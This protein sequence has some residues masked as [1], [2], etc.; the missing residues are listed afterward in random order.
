MN[1]PYSGHD[2]ALAAAARAGDPAALNELFGRQLPM[3]YNLVRR[4][5]HDDPAVDDVVQDVLVRAL[6]QIGRLRS[7]GSFRPWLAA[8]AVRQIS[9]H[10]ARTEV[11]A[12]REAPLEAAYRRP[13]AGAEVEGPALLRAELSGQRR[14]VGHAL[15]WMGADE[16]ATYSLWW[17]EMLG[18]LSRPEV[19][20]ALGTSVAHAGVRMQ[21]MREQLEASRQIVAAL[22]AMPGC[23]TLGQVAAEWDGTPSSFWRKRLGRHVQS[24]PVCARATARLLPAD[25]LLVGLM[26]FPVPAALGAAAVAKALGGGAAAASGVKVAS[27]VASWLGRTVQAAVTHPV[28]ATVTAGVLAVGVTVPT[29]G[30]TTSEAPS[31]GLIGTTAPPPS[32]SAARLAIGRVSLESAGAPGR[33]VAVAADYGVLTAVGPASDAAARERAGLSAVA[34]LA[35]PAC[36]SFRRPDGRY[37]RHSSFRLRLSTAD[38]TVLFR[39]DATFCARTG[40]LGGSV[41]LESFN[42]RGFFLRHVG[43]QMWIDQYDGSTEFRADG[44]FFVRPPLG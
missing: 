15:R 37:L 7:V 42:Y 4:A 3:V 21:R 11:A 40:F 44:S 26:L 29:T 18:E 32:A 22:E 38:G 2:E 19:A 27:G 25:R 24:C 1:Q 6:R 31:S 8:I 33:Y 5:L 23:A 36:F 9:S 39:Q 34:G 20:T 28:A 35:D 43:D 10:L 41:S 16:R 17:L 14:Q 12:R 30:W 13:D